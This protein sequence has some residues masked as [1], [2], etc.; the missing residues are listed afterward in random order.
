VIASELAHKLRQ[1]ERAGVTLSA[2][3]PAIMAELAEP[4][5]DADA[6]AAAIGA[7]GEPEPPEPPDEARRSAATA[8]PEP[9]GALARQT[10]P[11]GS[12]A[13]AERKDSE[14]KD[15]E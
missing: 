15:S 9:P 6:E 11:G 5:T 12:H 4:E 14:R 1:N 2:E 13:P 8:S 7:L 10:L 3:M